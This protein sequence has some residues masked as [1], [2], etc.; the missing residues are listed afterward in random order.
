MAVSLANRLALASPLV[1]ALAVEANE[2]PELAHRFRVE[3]VPKTIV[4]RKGAFVG[5]LPEDQF[6]AA[7][8]ELAQ[9]ADGR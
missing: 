3:G 7:V 4:N 1:T 9:A 6:V 2:F 8:L 5:A